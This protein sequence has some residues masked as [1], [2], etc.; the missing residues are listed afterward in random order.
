MEEDGADESE[1]VV[2]ALVTSVVI[3]R[4]EKIAKESY[5]PLSKKQTL[6][7]IGLID[8]VSYSVEKTSPRFGVRLYSLMS[9]SPVAPESHFH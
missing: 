3:P 9:L 4:L 8:E 7:A 6:R 2:N 5:D 1:L